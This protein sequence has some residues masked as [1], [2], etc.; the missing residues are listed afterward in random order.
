MRARHVLL[1][2]AVATCSVTGLLVA[3]GGSADDTAPPDAGND[4]TVDAPKDVAPDVVVDAGPAPCD[5]DADLFTMPLPDGSIGDSGGTV[6]ACGTC[7]KTSCQSDISDCNKL[8]ECKGDVVALYNCLAQGKALQTCGIQNFIG[9][10]PETQNIGISLVGC[11]SS[12]CKVECG[13][14]DAG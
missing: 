5:T 3:C 9:A 6:P 10:S 1:L 13:L 12:K 14:G 7:L 11:A 2:L 4:V 8:C